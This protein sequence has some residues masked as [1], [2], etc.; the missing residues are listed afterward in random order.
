MKEIMCHAQNNSCVIVMSHMGGT[1]R[2]VFE[3]REIYIICYNKLFIKVFIDNNPYVLL[4][5]VKLLFLLKGS[6]GFD[7]E[8]DTAS[9][10]KGCMIAR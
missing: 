8:S 5:E 7:V 9:I 4:C 6:G 2:I 1:P 3:I 10:E